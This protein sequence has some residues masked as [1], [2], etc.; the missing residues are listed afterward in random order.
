[1]KKITFIILG[2]LIIIVSG[3]WFFNPKN[4]LENLEEIPKV[5]KPTEITVTTLE[6]NVTRKDYSIQEESIVEKT[7]STTEGD[8]IRTSSTGRALLESPNGHPTILDYSTE[9]TITNS[10]EQGNKTKFELF[11]GSL[12]SRAKKTAEKGEFFE[13]KTGNAVAVVRG[14][15]FGL[16]WK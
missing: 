13:I 10:E 4:T 6:K 2:L 16:T 12:W 9:L 14:T 15:S 11:G 5:S 7:A 1:M 8:I 3:L